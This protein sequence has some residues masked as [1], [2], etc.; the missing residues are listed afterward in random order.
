MK[1]KNR[2]LVISIIFFSI[3]FLISARLISNSLDSITRNQ[4]IEMNNKDLTRNSQLINEIDLQM[5]LGLTESE[6]TSFINLYKN[7]KNPLPIIKIEG[8]TYYSIKA[9]DRW[10]Q[11]IGQK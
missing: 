10:L 7:S 6:L 2:L 1:Y 8:K 4:Q 9:I 11:N 5:Y 3:C